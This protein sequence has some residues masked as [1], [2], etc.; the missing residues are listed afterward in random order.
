MKQ[1]SS[2]SIFKKAS[3]TYYYSSIF[4]PKEVRQDVYD[5]Y[6]FVRVADDYVDSQPAKE[7]LFTRF[8]SETIQALSGKKV[9]NPVIN[10]LIKLIKKY[11]FDSTWIIAFLDA[12][13]NDLHKKQ[14][15]T[16]TD[17]EKYIHGSAEVVGLL[18]AKI[19]S[20]PKQSYPYAQAL[21]KS[22][23][24]INFLRDIQ[25]DRDLGRL[26]IPQEDLNRF[27]L[28]NLLINSEIEKKQFIK[29]MHFEIKRYFNIQKQA[30]KGYEFIPRRFL[31]P[32]KTASD[33][34]N[35]TAKQIDENPFLVFQKKIKPKSWQ[36]FRQFILNFL[37][38]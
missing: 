36:V 31:L 27:N 1:I 25:E 26:Y 18:M 5:L 17:L 7:K 3:V 4:F 12:M 37:R 9:N 29:L 34:Y 30:E 16:F 22:M 20:L 6:A 8:Y 21:G 28:R 10:N 38:R 14:Y 13:K 2:Q 35:W 23:Q 33:M 15:Q 32:I 24:L 11:Q 19:L